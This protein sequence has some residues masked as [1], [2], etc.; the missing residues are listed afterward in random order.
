[1]EPF[2]PSEHRDNGDDW[3]KSVYDRLMYEKER[4]RKEGEDLAGED[5]SFLARIL[6]LFACVVMALPLVRYFNTDHHLEF[7]LACCVLFLALYQ[8]FRK[9]EKND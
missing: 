6:F 8:Y 1:M 5:H 7:L 4:R 2:H 3:E 9:K